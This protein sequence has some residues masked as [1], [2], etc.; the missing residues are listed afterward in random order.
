MNFILKIVGCIFVVTSSTFLGFLL[1]QKLKN[2]CNFLVALLD[3][4]CNLKTNIR[5]SGDDI[6]SVIE[7]SVGGILTD[8]FISN[9]NYSILE[10]WS[11]CIEKIPA[12]YGL[13]QE[14]YN[15]LKDFCVNLGSTDIEGQT[16]HIELYNGL[17]N[18]QLEKAK[19]EY[20]A[21]SK[22]YKLL[23]F[24]VG[25]AVAIMII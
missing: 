14:D 3:F 16:S 19:V 17:L 2:R 5:F 24:F 20:T 18:T 21:K 13:T 6:F 8:I 23:G 10:Y 25:S 9:N 22:L 1:A 4:L 7:N 11:E 12:S 15:I